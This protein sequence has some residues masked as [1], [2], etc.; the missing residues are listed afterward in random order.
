MTFSDVSEVIRAYDN[1]EV[2]LAS[3]VTVRITE[4]SERCQSE[5]PKFVPKITRYE[6]TVGRAHPV[7][8]SADGPAV[9][10]C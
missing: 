7:G 3:R 2:E 9:H 8:N 4:V 10:A 1:K 6:T 5:R